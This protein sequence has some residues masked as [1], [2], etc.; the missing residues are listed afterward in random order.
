MAFCHHPRDK[1]LNKLP[2]YELPLRVLA[3]IFIRNRMCKFGMVLLGRSIKLLTLTQCCLKQT[4]QLS[5]FL[6]TKGFHGDF[7][8][9]MGKTEY[10]KT[11][12]PSHS[13]A[14]FTHTV[15]CYR[16]QAPRSLK[17]RETSRDGLIY[18]FNV[19]AGANLHQSEE[20]AL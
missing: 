15:Y 10:I 7:F 19:L 5:P 2:A 9:N 1:S 20:P 3:I 4:L 14:H 8:K 18:Q 12:F 13:H 17:T 11:H 16:Y 6:N